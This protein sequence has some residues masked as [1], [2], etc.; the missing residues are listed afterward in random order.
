[1]HLIE[2]AFKGNRKEFFAWDGEEPPPVR[3]LIMSSKQTAARTSASCTRRRARRRSATPGATHGWARRRPTRKA[4]RVATTRELRQSARV[5]AQDETARRKA[6]GTRQGAGPRDEAV[7]RRM[8]VG[9]QE[10][11]DLFH[12]RKA[13][14][15]PRAGAR[16]RGDCSARA[17]QMRQ[18]GVRDEAKRLDGVGRCGRQFCSA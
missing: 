4:L 3:A 5:R 8:A 2:V 1:M 11:H 16:P 10:T 13:R 17:I 9:P 12:R 15:L 6:D 18:I 14:R 7:R